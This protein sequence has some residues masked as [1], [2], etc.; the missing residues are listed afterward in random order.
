MEV[1]NKS[2]GIYLEQATQKLEKSM[3][4]LSSGLRIVSAADDPAGLAIAD[5]LNNDAVVYKRGTQN[6]IEASLGNDIAEGAL[7]QVS[8]IAGRLSELAEQASNGTLS[9]AQRSTLNQEYQSLKQEIDRIGATTQFNGQ[10][11]LQ[12]GSGVTAQ[13]G[14]D[15]STNSQI[16]GTSIDL[17]S[18]NQSSSIAT[19]DQARAALDQVKGLTQNIASAAGQL[20]AINNR[21]QVAEQYN[22][23]AEENSRAAESRIRDVDVAAEAAN[24]TS[25][26]IQQNVAVALQA[27]SN[28]S[29]DIVSKLLK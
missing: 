27:H 17:S 29:A 21:L 25:A 2:R 11:L 7:G 5:A 10:Q 1:N 3:S 4:K 8:Q 16:S 12:G 24:R 19:Q 26:K 9:D 15:G 23:V 6:A 18:I 14:T 13:V 20:G 22:R 28:L